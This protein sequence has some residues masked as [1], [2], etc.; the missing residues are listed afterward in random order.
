MKKTDI[1][2]FKTSH[3]LWHQLATFPFTRSTFPWVNSKII[4]PSQK[5]LKLTVLV[6]NLPQQ[7]KQAQTE[8]L[9]QQFPES[10]LCQTTY[11]F[12]KH[13]GK[14]QK[15]NSIPKTSQQVNRKKRSLL[16]LSHDNGKVKSESKE[17]SR[18]EDYGNEYYL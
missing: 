2:V 1:R 13:K 3:Q 4:N 9:K 18:Q 16:N 17:N 7:S 5:S 11:F 8:S 15:S 12:L 6:R 14:W 10:T